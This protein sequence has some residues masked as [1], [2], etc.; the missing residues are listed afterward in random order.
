MGDVWLGSTGGCRGRGDGGGQQALSFARRDE[1]PDRAIWRL[2]FYDDLQP[3]S[4][5][6]R[7]KN[8]DLGLKKYTLNPSIFVVPIGI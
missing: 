4:V 2:G 6:F 3:K 5:G 1:D 7:H 8:S